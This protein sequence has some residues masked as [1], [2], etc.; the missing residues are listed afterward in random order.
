[1]MG[2]SFMF[3]GRLIVMFVF[4]VEILGRYLVGF[5]D[6]F[7]LVFTKRVLTLFLSWRN[8]LDFFFRVYK[9]SLRVL[10]LCFNSVCK[11]WAF[12]FDLLHWNEINFLLELRVIFMG[13]NYVNGIW[14][15]LKFCFINLSRFFWK[16]NIAF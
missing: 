16:F 4:V 15:F 14:F 3:M 10:V 8:S 7:W 2:K 9:W 12:F 1:M 13:V 6:F 5:D 11:N